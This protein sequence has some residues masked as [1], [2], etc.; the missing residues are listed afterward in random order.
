VAGSI[1]FSLVFLPAFGAG[2]AETA[3]TFTDVRSRLATAGV[4][5]DPGEPVITDFPI[6]LPYTRGG[7]ALA[8]P[9]EP[10][11]SVLD[12]A[13]HFGAK[14]VAILEG[15]ALRDEIASGSADARCFED[16][17]PPATPALGGHSGDTLHVYRIVCP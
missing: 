6:W 10:A 7:T 3:R 11:S 17:T 8:L 14:T 9:H 13:R 1:L 4:T 2:S 15:F 5:T 12:L 16:V